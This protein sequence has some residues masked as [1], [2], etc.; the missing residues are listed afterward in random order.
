MLCCV[1]VLFSVTGSEQSLS[2]N[3]RCSMLTARSL[4]LGEL[5]LLC[6]LAAGLAHTTVGSTEL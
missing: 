6:W 1:V 5:C 3:A 2:R 4:V